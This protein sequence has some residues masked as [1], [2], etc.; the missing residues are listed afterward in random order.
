MHGCALRVRPRQCET[1]FVFCHAILHFHCLEQRCQRL[2]TA[3]HRRA[4]QAI[5]SPGLNNLD[6]Q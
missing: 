1:R 2:C 3:C 5:P 6:Q 4:T